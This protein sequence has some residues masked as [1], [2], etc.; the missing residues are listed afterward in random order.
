MSDADL[1][2]N[3]IRLAAEKPSLRPKLLPLLMKHGGKASIEW[4]ESHQHTNWYVKKERGKDTAY[5]YPQKL[6]KDGSISG[7]MYVDD[8][9]KRNRAKKHKVRKSDFPKWIGTKA[10]KVP[11]RARNLIEQKV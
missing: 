1:R 9:A 2:K 8:E 5:F 6:E 3:L 11:M 4:W 7:Y 10:P